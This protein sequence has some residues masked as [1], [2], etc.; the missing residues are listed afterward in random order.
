MASFRRV[1]KAATVTVMGVSLGETPLSSVL[2]LSC[3]R[4]MTLHQPD[5]GF[6]ERMLATCS[7]CRLW[8]LWDFDTDSN[9]AVVVLL[10]DRDYFK[11]IAG[12]SG[13]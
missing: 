2:C 10:P 12:G 4:E 7:H 13:A 11:S 8:Y 3:D 1:N 5:D 6:P 9:E